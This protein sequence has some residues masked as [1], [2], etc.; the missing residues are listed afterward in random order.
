MQAIVRFIKRIIE[1]WRNRG[2]PLIQ[3]EEDDAVLTH[4]TCPNCDKAQK[5]R[6]SQCNETDIT[7]PCCDGAYC[8]FAATDRQC[9]AIIT[10]GP[11]ID[12]RD[13]GREQYHE[14]LEKREADAADLPIDSKLAR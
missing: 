11:P 8:I 9:A 4:F 13:Y 5:L 14:W 12:R 3:C 6:I 1:R 7:C 2:A 10:P